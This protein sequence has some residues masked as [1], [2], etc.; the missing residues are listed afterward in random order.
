MHEL[1][2]ARFQSA[3]WVKRR[4]FV[5][6]FQKAAVFVL[7]TLTFWPFYLAV[8]FADSLWNRRY[9]DVD[10]KR[11]T[12]KF[13][14]IMQ[15]GNMRRIAYMHGYVF[16]AACTNFRPLGFSLLAGWI[17][18]MVFLFVSVENSMTS[19]ERSRKEEKTTWN[20]FKPVW[21]G[22]YRF[23]TQTRLEKRVIIVSIKPKTIELGL[24]TLTLT[25]N[26]ISTTDGRSLTFDL[27][28]GLITLQGPY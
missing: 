8:F 26:C 11:N 17:C 6:T 9:V 12:S 18:R 13:L 4:D 16:L 21:T 1:S 22:S 3:S 19:F 2:S 7:L 5:R 10:A 14:D 23:C 28:L 25:S 15:R 24:L 20:R 27:S